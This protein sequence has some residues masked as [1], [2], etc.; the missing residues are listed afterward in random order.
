MNVTSQNVIQILEAADKI[1]ATDMKK[2][3]LSIIVHHFSKVRG[4]IH[5]EEH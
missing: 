5:L 4:V 3:A 2:H 1:Q